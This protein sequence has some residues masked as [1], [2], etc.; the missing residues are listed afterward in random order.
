VTASNLSPW[1]K[2]RVIVDR[3]S[4]AIVSGAFDLSTHDAKGKKI[5]AREDLTAPQKER[6]H[7]GLKNV[8]TLHS[9]T[10]YSAKQLTAEAVSI[11]DQ[12]VAASAVARVTRKNPRAASE[13]SLVEDAL[14]A[15]RAA[16]PAWGVVTQA[17]GKRWPETEPR[18]SDAVLGFGW[19]VVAVGKANVTQRVK[20]GKTVKDQA[21]RRLVADFDDKR[22][23]YAKAIRELDNAVSDAKKERLAAE[24]PSDL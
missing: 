9:A 24:E 11:N 4:Q 3:H 18:E 10:K 8:R 22:K 7:Q 5:D 15:L 1:A 21:R 23:A 6:K 16:W 17:E 19:W 20:Y 12:R 2:N 14:D 13:L